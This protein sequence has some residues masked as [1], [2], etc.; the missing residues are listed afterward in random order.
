MVRRFA[1]GSETL[2]P[3][4]DSAWIRREGFGSLDVVIQ[5]SCP[6]RCFSG[7]RH[8]PRYA[9]L[10]TGERSGLRVDKA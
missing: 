5:A 6:S 3:G 4:A 7:R 8:D 1:L 2:H 9:N 10:P